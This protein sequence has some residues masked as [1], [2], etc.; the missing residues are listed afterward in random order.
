MRALLVALLMS[1]AGFANARDAAP[2]KGRAARPRL[3][4]ASSA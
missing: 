1:F 2:S 4:I 3:S